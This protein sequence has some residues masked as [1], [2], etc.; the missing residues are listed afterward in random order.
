MKDRR[1][2]HRAPRR[3]A[4]CASSK[5]ASSLQA[6]ADEL[7]QLKAAGIQVVRAIG[8]EFRKHQKD[9]GELISL[10]VGKIRAEGAGEVQE[11]IDIVASWI[12]ANAGQYGISTDN[13]DK[14]E[15]HVDA[16]NDGAK[17]GPSAGIALLIHSC[18]VIIRA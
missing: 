7:A 17:D 9:L 4:A 1:G 12:R 10:E 3:S 11:S 2:I 8:D 5:R 13:L 18:S 16:V 14:T 15:L 6:R